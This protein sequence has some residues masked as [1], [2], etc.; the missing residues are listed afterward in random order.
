MD[1]R[2]QETPRATRDRGCFVI[3]I[4]LS[5]KETFFGKI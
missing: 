1:D 2:P 3:E 5:E 4:Y